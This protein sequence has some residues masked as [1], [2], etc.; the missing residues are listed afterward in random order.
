MS[1]VK[2]A[3]ELLKEEHDHQSALAAGKKDPVPEFKEK[4]P[5]TPDDIIAFHFIE[6]GFSAWGEI[7]YRGQEVKIVKGSDAYNETVDREG[8]TWIDLVDKPGKQI[9][10]WKKIFLV[11]GPWE[12]EPWTD[13]KAK[14]AE[15]RRAGS[16]VRR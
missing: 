4:D 5:E 8:N 13:P 15:E 3:E 10:R 7:W 6:D 14:L 1:N 9:A 16:P 11:P 2:T 12:G